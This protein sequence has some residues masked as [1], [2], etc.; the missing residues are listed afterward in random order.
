MG[1][2]VIQPVEGQSGDYAKCFDELSERSVQFE[3]TTAGAAA[4]ALSEPARRMSLAIAYPSLLCS[5]RVFPSSRPPQ[6]PSPQPYLL[7]LQPSSAAKHSTSN[8]P[9]LS[10]LLPPAAHCISAARPA[11]IVLSLRTNKWNLIPRRPFSC[12]I[13]QTFTHA[14][15]LK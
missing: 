8:L 7:T 3:S 1:N 15:Q 5:R 2:V 9:R 4:V 12:R 6:P 11:V 10:P 14:N 13:V